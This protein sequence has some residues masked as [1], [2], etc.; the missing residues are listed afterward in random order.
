MSWY[1][2]ADRFY[3]SR[4][5]AARAVGCDIIDAFMPARLKNQDLTFNIDADPFTLA[6]RVFLDMPGLLIDT[7]DT[8]NSDLPNDRFLTEQLAGD[9]LV[10]W[11]NAQTDDDAIR[12]PDCNPWADSR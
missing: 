2:R 10:E 9:L 3:Q 6:R 7:I 11:R 12:G 1:V 8:F 4:K 5:P